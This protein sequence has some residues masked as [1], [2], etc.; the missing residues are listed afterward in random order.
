LLLQGV[1]LAVHEALEQFA[2][3]NDDYLPCMMYMP[4]GGKPRQ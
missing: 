2:M 1:G 4:A 3:K